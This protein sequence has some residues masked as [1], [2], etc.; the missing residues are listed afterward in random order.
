MKSPVRDTLS[1]LGEYHLSQYPHRIKLNQNENP[2]ELPAE[3]KDEILRRFASL[4]WSR[5]P[6]F[7]PQEQIDLVARFAGWQPE[8][9]LLGNGSNDL[10]QVIFAAVLE[11]GRCVVLSQPTFTLYKLLGKASG[12]DVLDVPMLPG[13]LFDVDQIIETVRKVNASMVVI[14]SPNNPTGTHLTEDEVKR[15]V[16]STESLVVLDEA[17]IQFAPSSRVRLLH[18]YDRLVILQTFSKAMGAASFRFGYALTSPQLARQLNKIK[19]PY[20][21]NAFTLAAAEVLIDRWSR[22]QTWISILV[23]ERERMY[24]ALSSVNQVKVYPSAGNFLLFESLNKP[25]PAVFQSLL[26]SGILIRDVSSYPMLAQGLRVSMGKPEEND[27][28]LCALRE[29]L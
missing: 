22:I 15:I 16:E 9:T 3:I 2:Y 20:S 18:D 23:G 13:F 8:G 29:A 28:F 1:S 7:I 10:L 24:R 14:C 26:R 4:P 12:A 5:Y 19:L 21:V 17:Y 6:Q 25:P 27:E 11:A